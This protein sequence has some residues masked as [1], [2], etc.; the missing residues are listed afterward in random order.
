MTAAERPV[1]RPRPTSASSHCAPVHKGISGKPNADYGHAETLAKTLGNATDGALARVA[2]G[3]RQ[4][5]GCQCRSECKCRPLDVY[6]LR[7]G[8]Y[9]ESA[10]VRSP[11]QPTVITSTVDQVGSRLLFRGYGVSD[12]SKPLH[13]ALV[14]NDAIILLDEAHCAK[15][16]DQTMALVLKYRAWTDKPEDRLTLPFH[17]VT[18]TATPTEGTPE[19]DIERLGM[20][21]RNDPDLGKRIKAPKRARLVIAETAKG[22]KWREG[23]VKVLVER[24][25]GLQDNGHRAIGIIVNRVA[26]ARDT[27]AKLRAEVG[28]GAD[29]ILLTGRMRPMDRDA[30]MKTLEPLLSKNSRTSNH[31][32]KPIFVVATQTIEVGADLDFHALGTECASLDALRQ[33]FGRLNRVAARDKAE[34]VIVVRA[35]QT[36]PAKDNA[37]ADP[38]YGNSLAITWQWLNQHAKDASTTVTASDTN[39]GAEPAGKRR[40]KHANARAAT[41]AAKVIDF[42]VEAMEALTKSMPPDGLAAHNAPAPDAAVLLPAHLDMWCQTSPRPVP[43]PDPSYFLHGPQRGEPEVQVVFRADLGGDVDQWTEIVSLC[44]P[45]SSEALSVRLRD[46]RR[47]LLNQDLDE[48]TG[49][50]E[51]ERIEDKAEDT[52]AE[53]VPAARRALRWRGPGSRETAVIDAPGAVTPNDTYVVPITNDD[54]RKAAALLGDFPTEPDGTPKLT[55]AGDEAFQKSRDKAI[56]RIV[57]ALFALKPVG[58]AESAEIAAESSEDSPEPTDADCLIARL[59]QSVAACHDDTDDEAEIPEQQLREALNAIRE[60]EKTRPDAERRAW[61]LNSIDAILKERGPR[62]S[63]CP[64]SPAA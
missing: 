14:G 29:V 60:I 46:F 20:D 26:T 55:D 19:R 54:Q 64:R 23:L 16:F 56:L 47:W 59:V 61:L 9:R 8:M 30:V 21:D 52:Q 1:F 45:S 35:D 18:M 36:E 24:A 4:I 40:G 49:D 5:A 34:A 7:G 28:E 53:S 38:V 48:R 41:T 39:P 32:I 57:P 2:A 31:R 50:V 63:R 25:R 44:P 27:A 37:G 3:L 6:A 11:L 17:F 33:R 62:R 42:G 13:A 15:P 10:W 58:E 12:A 43:D 22:K 51:G